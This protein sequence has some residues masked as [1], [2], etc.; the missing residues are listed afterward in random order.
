MEGRGIALLGN[1]AAAQEEERPGV[2][3]VDVGDLSLARIDYRSRPIT[4]GMFA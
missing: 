3:E 2:E 4:T 1:E